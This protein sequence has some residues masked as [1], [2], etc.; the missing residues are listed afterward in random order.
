MTTTLRSATI[1]PQAGHAPDAGS[2]APAVSAT[3]PDWSREAPRRWWDPSRRLL[4]AIRRYQAARRRGGPAGRIAAKYWAVQHRFWSVVTQAEI[5]L[6]AEIGGGLLLPH[7]NGVVIHPAVR[8][9][10]N[11][12]ILQQVTLGWG[13]DGVPA[14]GGHVDIG[15]G[16]RVIGAVRLGDHSTVGA[17]A[18]VTRDVPAGKVATGVP[19]EIRAP[20]GAGKTRRHPAGNR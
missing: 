8:I 16:A 6:N 18:V 15:A 13:R 2:P 11:C 17:N 5:D 9:G 10:P 19:A 4:R 20:G 1:A 3:I 7:P 12:L 14:L